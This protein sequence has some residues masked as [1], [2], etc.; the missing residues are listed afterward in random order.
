MHG[1]GISNNSFTVLICFYAPRGN[2]GSINT[3]VGFSS[4]KAYA[5]AKT[6]IEVIGFF[7][8]VSD[9]VKIKKL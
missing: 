1:K 4:L 3:F 5:T 7:Y 2:H 8:G 6:K 9:G